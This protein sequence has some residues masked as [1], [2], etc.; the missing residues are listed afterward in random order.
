MD[1]LTSQLPHREIQSTHWPHLKDL[2]LADPNFSKPKDIDC[3]IGA[4]AYARIILNG[5]K[6]G[7][8]S[9][10]IAQ[11]TELGWILVG[12]SVPASSDYTDNYFVNSFFVNNKGSVSNAL[13]KQWELEKIPP[14]AYLSEEEAA[15]EK[16][17]NE[18]YYR[19]DGRYGVCLP[20]EFKPS[21]PGSRKIA[22]SSWSR[23]SKR[24]AKNSTL[25]LA[26]DDFMKEYLQLGHMASTRERA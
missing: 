1:R 6:R 13:V 23:L 18:T 16:H 2:N 3:L 17:F 7:P 11:N 8:P 21:L 12:L 25:K 24:L 20:F 9:A 4:E 19:V 22:S 26:Y 10:P 5:I 15:C 14:K